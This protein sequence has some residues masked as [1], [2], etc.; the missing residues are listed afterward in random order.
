[1]KLPYHFLKAGGLCESFLPDNRTW[2]EWDRHKT[3]WTHWPQLLGGSTFCPLAPSSEWAELAR[4]LRNFIVF[5]TS[6]WIRQ[7]PKVCAIYPGRRLSWFMP[8]T[9]EGCL[10]SCQ[11]PGKTL[12]VYARYIYLTPL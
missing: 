4:A 7:M 1:L 8:V 6:Y 12:P 2:T 10:G 9:R 11:L 5:C 3:P